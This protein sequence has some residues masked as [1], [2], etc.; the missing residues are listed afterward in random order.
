[1]MSDTTVVRVGPKGRIV[2]PAAVRRRLGIT[3][4]TELCVVATDRGVELYTRAELV[5]ELQAPFEKQR[6]HLVDDLLAE[7][8]RAAASEDAKLR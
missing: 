1:M 7:R 8:R 3:E 6:G 4:G 2:L 5:R